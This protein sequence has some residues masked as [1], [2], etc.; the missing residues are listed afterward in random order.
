MYR[1]TVRCGKVR[2]KQRQD[3]HFQHQAL[4]FEHERHRHSC[5]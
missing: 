4:I 1:K 3:C 5:K 2:R